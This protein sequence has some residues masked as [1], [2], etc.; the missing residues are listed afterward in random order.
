MADE[1]LYGADFD[2][3]EIDDDDEERPWGSHAGEPSSGVLAE[4]TC[5]E[6]RGVI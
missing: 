3:S 4:A 1:E 6:I 5:D 2:G